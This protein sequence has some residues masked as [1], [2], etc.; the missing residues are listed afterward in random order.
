MTEPKWLRL[1]D[2]EEIH[3]EQL[4]LFG[5]PA[6]IRDLGLLE[7][8]L[9]RAKNRWAYEQGG[10]PQLA[11]AY[12]FGIARNHPFV[13]G[14]K[15]TAFACLMVFLRYNGVRFAPPSAEATAIMLD[16]AAGTVDEADLTRW[17]ETNWPRSP[18]EDADKR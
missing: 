15:R 1:A 11:A 4:A 9:D 14:N 16:L 12:A 17:I 2:V 7:S 6:G 18:S 8:A 13:D 10:L 3:E 5:G